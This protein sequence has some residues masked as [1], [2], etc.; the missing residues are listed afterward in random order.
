MS[1]IFT[2]YSYHDMH[3]FLETTKKKQI[4]ENINSMAYNGL[5]Q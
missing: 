4:A 3:F 1:N 2:Q 5:A